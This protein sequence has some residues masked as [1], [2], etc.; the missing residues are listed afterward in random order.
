MPP[1]AHLCDAPPP[2]AALR[3]LRRSIARLRR[4]AMGC[5][6]CGGVRLAARA[7]RAHGQNYSLATLCAHHVKPA[8]KKIGF[9]TSCVSEI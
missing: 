8:R 5:E 7:R 3:R 6:A 1:R 9:I 2:G 4:V